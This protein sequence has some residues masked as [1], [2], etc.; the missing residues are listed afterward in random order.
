VVVAVEVTREQLE[1][2][3]VDWKLPLEDQDRAVAEVV[4]HKQL[5]VV[6]DIRTVAHL[7]PLA[8]LVLVGQEAP[9]GMPAVAVA[10]EAGTAAEAAVRM[11]TTVALTVAEAVA[12]LPTQIQITPRMF[13]MLPALIQATDESR[14]TTHF[15]LL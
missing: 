3:A 2:L 7:E 4:A 6:L 10:V 1:L 15:C 12:D 13:S 14:F 9:A 5:A 8:Y 11:T